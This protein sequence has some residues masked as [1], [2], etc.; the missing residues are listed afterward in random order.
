MATLISVLYGLL[1][2]GI[3]VLIHE[4]GHFAAAKFFGVRVET[5]SIGMGQGII[6]YKKGDTVYQ[7]GY[8]PLGGFC[9]M[10]GE[11]PSDNLTG[12]DWEFYSKSPGQRLIIL[13]A[14]PF[15]NYL[16]GIVLLIIIN[17]VGTY[18]STFSTRIDVLKEIKVGN[19]SITSPAY[20]YG[21]KNN[22]IIVKFNGREVK[23]WVRL[24]KYIVTAGDESDIVLTVKRGKKLIDVKIKPVINPDTGASLVG[25]IPYIGNKIEMVE[26]GSP[27]DK[28]KLRPE[29]IIL[30]VNGKKVNKFLEIKDI[31]NNY[32]N[33]VITLKVKRNKK[34]FNVRLKTSERDKKGYLGVAFYVKKE[35]IKN[36]SKNIFYAVYDSVKQANKMV[37][38]IIYGLKIMFSGKVRV[39]K[40]VSGPVKIVYFA[41]SMAQKYGFLNY[42]FIVAYI[43][44]ALAFF[45]LLPIP[46]VDGS[47]ILFFLFE[48]ISRR[49]LNYNV[50]RIIQNVGLG[51]IILLGVLVIFNDIWSLSNGQ[52]SFQQ[53][54]SLIETLMI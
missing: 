24:K 16:L 23:S 35:V 19:K 45:N 51:L 32:P 26:K 6:K 47:Y 42:L 11:E 54:K 5:F 27:A 37:G 14:G 10:A 52:A 8:I 48:L 13:F 30:A 25:I 39:G 41:G 29:D 3:L 46:A 9:K 40:A 22:D 28:A 53:T 34:V 36:K 31:V 44:I 17:S 18:T 7:L 15:M 33:K 20:K 43:S 12:A 21:L 50:L 49:K 4:L 1:A 2:L 38:D